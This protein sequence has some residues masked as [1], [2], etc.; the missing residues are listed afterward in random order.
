MLSIFFK[1]IDSNMVSR[2]LVELPWALLD[3]FNNAFDNNI[4]DYT[5]TPEDFPASATIIVK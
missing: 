5:G 1:N 3:S 2:W 4:M